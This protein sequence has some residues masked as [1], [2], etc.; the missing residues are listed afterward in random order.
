MVI[1]DSTTQLFLLDDEEIAAGDKFAS[2]ARQVGEI[3]LRL[4]CDLGLEVQAE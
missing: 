2:N 4:I 3:A 1:F